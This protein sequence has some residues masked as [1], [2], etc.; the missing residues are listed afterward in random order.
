MATYSISRF[1]SD[2]GVKIVSGAASGADNL[3]DS[4]TMTSS[5]R[6]ETIYIEIPS[7]EDITVSIQLPDS[8]PNVKLFSATATSSAKS[9]AVAACRIAPAGS[10]ISI[11]TTNGISGDKKWSACFGGV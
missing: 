8:G 3:G 11:A 1:P 10:V 6:I 4:I 2:E 9:F 5:G 7:T